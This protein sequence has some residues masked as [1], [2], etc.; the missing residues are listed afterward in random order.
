MRLGEEVIGI[1][2]EVFNGGQ[3]GEGFHAKLAVESAAEGIED[4]ILFLS[5]VPNYISVSAGVTI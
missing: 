1:L 3:V 4:L 5:T 2:D